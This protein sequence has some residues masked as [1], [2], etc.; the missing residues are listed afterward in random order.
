MNQKHIKKLLHSADQQIINQIANTYQATDNKTKEKIYQKVCERKNAINQTESIAESYHTD[1]IK[2][3]P[4][5]RAFGIAMACV[6]VMGG[7]V[8]GIAKLSRLNSTSE[9]NN[10]QTETNANTNMPSMLSTE[11]TTFSETST[12][13]QITSQSILQTAPETSISTT[14]TQTSIFTSTT[15]TAPI[16]TITTTIKKITN[17]TVP[18]TRKETVI[19]YETTPIVTTTNLVTNSVIATTSLTAP[20]TEETTTTTTTTQTK[21]VTTRPDYLTAYLE[22]CEQN[23]KDS[24]NSLYCLYDIDKDGTPELVIQG[25]SASYMSLYTYADNQV[26]ALMDKWAYGV[27]NNWGYYIHP[28]NN[29]IYYNVGE[30]AG[31]IYH[32]VYLTITPE[33]TLVEENILTCVN[34]VDTLFEQYSYLENDDSYA[35]INGNGYYI[36]HEKTTEE[37]YNAFYSAH[38]P[39]TYYSSIRDTFLDYK[40]YSE[41]LASLPES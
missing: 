2:Y 21:P 8:G 5:T 9:N 17:T 14:S 41:F 35:Y 34:D 27:H 32:Y 23:E 37:E 15:Q 6:L 11:T 22:I 1:T 13:M 20:I 28:D 30:Y 3:M 25:G 29:S 36:N 39:E 24:N 18:S 31:L 19:A 26:Y 38:N 33:H 16:T 40:L 4:W 10:S 7:T 12:E